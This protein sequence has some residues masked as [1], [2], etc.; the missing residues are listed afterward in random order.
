MPISIIFIIDICTISYYMLYLIM[1]TLICI[2]AKPVA[3]QGRKTTGFLETAGL[4][5]VAELPTRGRLGFFCYWE[6]NSHFFGG[7]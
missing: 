4:H 3:R 1:H 6:L 5:L 2:Q 7:G